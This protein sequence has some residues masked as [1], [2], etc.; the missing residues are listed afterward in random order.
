[1]PNAKVET[2]FEPVSLK[3]NNKNEA[4]MYISIQSADDSKIYWCECDITV[5]PP[6]S[7]AYDKELNMGHTRIGM[8][9]PNGKIEKP[10]KLYT[11]PNNVPDDYPVSIVAYLYDEEG[12][13]FERIEQSEKI[14]CEA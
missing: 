6:L 14:K 13:I 7:L 2:R 11:R 8:I 10:I 12:A 9:K 1:M 4:I 5:R 3:A